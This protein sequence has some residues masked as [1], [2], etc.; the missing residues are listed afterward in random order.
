M[1]KLH[2][3]TFFASALA[4][5]ATPVMIAP[6]ASAAA[7][8]TY[9]DFSQLTGNLDNNYAY[10]KI[11]WT[12]N[13][14]ITIAKA[15][16]TSAPAGTVY[17]VD[18]E[19]VEFFN[20]RQGET[21][22]LLIENS[23]AS[24]AKGE[25]LD[26]L[27]KVNDIRGWEQG[28]NDDGT[29]KSSAGMQ[30][31]HHIEGTN[32]V[33]HPETGTEGVTST[34]LGS[35]DPIFFWTNINHAD[36][37]FTVQFC[38]KG[39]YNAASDSCT[40]DTSIKNV[41][42]TFFDF[43]ILYTG[44][45][46]AYLERPFASNEGIFFE[47]SSHTIYYNRDNAD[48]V[49]NMTA[50]IGNNGYAI[51]TINNYYYNGIFYGNSFFVTSTN[52]P[53]GT[54]SYRQTGIGWGVGAIFGSVLPYQMK[55]P[56]KTVDKTSARAGENVTYTIEQEVPNNATTTPDT[57]TFMSLHSNYDNIPEFR[58]YTSLTITDTFDRN[59][60]V[61]TANE[62]TIKDETGADKTSLFTV[63]VSGQKVDATAT[64]SALDSKDFYGHIYTMV[65][66]TTVKNPVNISPINN[67]ARTTYTPNGGTLNT[68]ESDPIQTKIMHTVITKYVDNETGREI[69][70][71]T[72]RDY[73]HGKS[74]NTTAASE[75]DLPERYIL[76]E[77][78]S[79]ASGTVESDIVVIYRY[80]PIHTITT[81]H[82]DDETGEPIADPTTEEYALGDKYETSPLEQL[83]H[84]Y[85]L[86]GRP[87][88]AS[89]IVDGDVEV[90]YRYKKVK[91]PNTI[92]NIA[93]CLG[94]FVI[95]GVTLPGLTFAI[96]RR[97]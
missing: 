85:S 82:I 8:V 81:R 12:D 33:D 87:N 14:T 65:V 55:K 38:K 15:A 37:L 43:D 21:F 7:S 83:P 90:I 35:G 61:P 42:S 28:D 29:P 18:S 9:K 70:P 89:G 40:A 30:L 47:D 72:S 86:S 10:S 16:G 74:Y 13:T 26:V 77:T 20:M 36:A 17:D 52:L 46:P 71:S 68:L 59:L 31:W 96:K 63:N 32:S 97:R 45:T 6:S 34:H 76:K 19:D 95:V 79:N 51:N 58:N 23:T 41:S 94:G 49:T 3:F 24:N 60:T 56:V 27:Y 39:T 53:N 11:Y 2:I 80:N 75:D 48:R 93:K 92:D 66:K 88:N 1:K 22:T 69:A 44:S 54:F 25:K 62:I 78:P 84:S 50:Q 91:N 5:L 57:V 67:L 73:E 4:L 64:S